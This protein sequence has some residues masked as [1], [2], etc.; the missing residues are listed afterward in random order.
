M[1]RP[2]LI[3][4]ITVVTLFAVITFM[5]QSGTKTSAGQPSGSPT[6]TEE[7]KRAVSHFWSTFEH[8]ESLRIAG[9]IDGAIKAYTD[10]LT[11]DSAH[12]GSLYWL[13][14]LLAEAG[15]SSQALLTF[16]RLVRCNPISARGH[17]RMG[18][19]LSSPLPGVPLDLSVAETH[20]QA[21][22]DLN[23]EES[24]PYYWLGRVNA[25]RGDI[26]K[27]RQMLNFA[28][29]INPDHIEALRVMAYTY[30]LENDLAQAAHYY[31]R[32]LK[33]GTKKAGGPIPGEG[34]TKKSVVAQDAVSARNIASFFGLA[35]VSQHPAGYDSDIDSMLRTRLPER[36]SCLAGNVVTFDAVSSPEAASI[37]WFDFDLDGDQD[38]MLV[39]PHASSS[40]WRNEGKGTFVDVTGAARLDEAGNGY[41]VVANDLDGDGDGDVVIVNSSWCF[42][43]SVSCWINDNGVFHRTRSWEIPADGWTTGAEVADMDLDGR[44]D[45]I[46]YGLDPSGQG[47][48]RVFAGGDNTWKLSAATTL[49]GAG[50]PVSCA[51]GDIDNDS[52]K[53]LFISRW[54]GTSVLFRT[55]S[56][57]QLDDITAKSGV[58]GVPTSMSAAF[59]DY[60][61]DGQVDLFVT[62]PAPYEITLRS[63]L[64]V[65]QCPDS[66]R[67]RLFANIGGGRF[68]RV[69]P[70]SALEGC[71]GTLDVISCD[72]NGDEYA[73]L[74]LCNGGF[75]YGRFEP[76]ALLINHLGQY[77][78]TNFVDYEPRKSYS[79]AATPDGATGQRYLAV[80]R[81]GPL[82]G[83]RGP[84]RVYVLTSP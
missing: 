62:V 5:R 84:L 18:Q 46:E 8:A 48:V 76:D 79:A 56:Q 41:Q 54:Q 64:G 37:A 42:K 47:R 65:E 53:E 50:V 61:G 30:A 11:I 29:G 33:T 81:S 58:D 43:G 55:T 38:I 26:A 9:D 59:L 44:V 16:E 71:Y 70:D 17:Q 49:S 15:Q 73:D 1:K 78:V 21:A 4:A 57:G 2:A 35:A 12:D 83:E 63:M 67:P 40:L 13:G 74:Y 6:M 52:R 51:V 69:A 45:L 22:L 36:Q 72:A 80:A 34:D 60:N 7:R 68:Q 66:C 23:R 3:L 20:L 27:A 19:I 32:A 31:H 82:P 10:V 24:G 14:N 75:E 28:L 39:S 77:F 25:I